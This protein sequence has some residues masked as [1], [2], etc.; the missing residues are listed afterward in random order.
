MA[1]A[2][3]K[4]RLTA[5]ILL[6]SPAAC[7]KLVYEH[8]EG[9]LSRG[10]FNFLKAVYYAGQFEDEETPEKRNR[11]IINDLADLDGVGSLGTRKGLKKDQY[12]DEYM[13]RQQ[14]ARYG[15]AAI[16]HWQQKYK[17]KFNWQMLFAAEKLAYDEKKA[18]KTF[19]DAVRTGK[20]LEKV[21]LAEYEGKTVYFG[22]LRPVMS[23]SD[24][25]QFKNYSEPA[26]MAGMKE[27]MKS[28]LEKKV[29]DQLLKSFFADEKELLRFDHN[30]VALLYLK[31]KY[32]KA[33]KGIYPG[34]MDK[35]VLK[36][37]EI[38]DHFYKMQNA[39]ADVLWV[40]AA[41]TVVAEESLSEELI[42][43]LDKGGDFAELARKYAAEPKFIPTARPAIIQ[44][45]TK[46]QRLDDKEKR[47]YYDRLIL[48]MAGR[49]VSK[50]EPY[51][52]RDGIVVVRI[53]DVSR[54]LE[55]V[56]L[57]DVSWK[58]END[59]R[60]K[61]LNAIYDQDIKDARDRLK[62]R[63]NE[64]LIKNLQ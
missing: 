42:Q 2:M 19:T 22:D 47:D 21:A 36:P 27:V 58:V 23:F 40:K 37:G 18:A 26:V 51:L 43:K 16:Y 62:I 50:P 25:E 35:I 4:I 12:Y 57:E 1:A 44:G 45:Y 64:R 55:K 53:Y 52:G 3:T 49:D 33:G 9:N 32:G 38:Y 7:S 48:D 24:Y 11:A 39:M 31:V 8:N 60:T 29:Y 14:H 30:R 28:W 6:L 13:F 41:Y 56:R 20:P 5:L 15:K 10:T 46:N 34:S 61:M 59:L 17:D 63:F 54:A